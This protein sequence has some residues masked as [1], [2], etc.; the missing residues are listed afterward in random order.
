MTDL[1]EE[2]LA[3]LVGRGFEPLLQKTSGALAIR[4]LDG[5][6]VDEWVLGVDQGNLTLRRDAGG[7]DATLT[8][9]RSLFERMVQ[10][11]ANATAAV[12]RGEARI[13]GDLELLM[14]VQRVFPGPDDADAVE[15]RPGDE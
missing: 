5:S 2:F 10:G 8:L 9:D 15:E 4:L 11:R 1:A 6:G 13:E 14:A 7:A 3:A 12:L